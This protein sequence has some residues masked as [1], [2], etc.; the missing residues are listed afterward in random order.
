MCIFLPDATLHGYGFYFEWDFAPQL[1]SDH[2]WFIY[3]L[4]LKDP[5][6]EYVPTTKNLSF[7]LN[8]SSVCEVKTFLCVSKLNSSELRV[9]ACVSLCISL[10]LPEEVPLQ[11]RGAHPVP[12][13]DPRRVRDP[14][15]LRGRVH[16]VQPGD[17]L[18]APSEPRGKF[19][20]V[21]RDVMITVKHKQVSASCFWHFIF[22]SITGRT[23][24][25]ASQRR[26]P[27]LR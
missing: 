2:H 20:P 18:P 4:K 6:L 24:N 11:T 10:Q 1:R 9:S 22:N 8:F 26:L 16:P 5:L 27:N 7:Y 23:R 15:L 3:V 19:H 17:E 25:S 12:A 13:S 21:V 14:V